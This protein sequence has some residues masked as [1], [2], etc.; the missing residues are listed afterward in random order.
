MGSGGLVGV[1]AALAN[2]AVTMPVAAGVT[3]KR[4]RYWQ[5]HVMSITV[6]SGPWSQSVIESW[7]REESIPL[8]LA[9]VGKHGPLVQSLWFSYDDGELWCATQA[10]SVV[11][12]RLRRDPRVGWEVSRDEPPYRGVRGTGHAELVGD[13]VRAEVVLKS[14]IERYGQ[15]GTE[16]ETWL[17]NRVSTEIAV[18]ITGLRVTSWDYTPRM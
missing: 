6:K 3:A 7:L 8:R 15:S 13:Q 1:C 4:D 11:A 18:R 2:G 12:K 17:I 14:L 9:T 10:E 5:A 16:L